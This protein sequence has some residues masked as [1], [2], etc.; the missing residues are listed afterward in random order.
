MQNKH[1][2]IHFIRGDL[3]GRSFVVP[4]DGLLIGKSRSAAIRPGD[5]EIEAEHALLQIREDQLILVSRTETVFVRE[6]QL[7]P[8]AECILEPGVDVRLGKNLSFIL[9]MDEGLPEDEI[10]GNDEETADEA[11]AEDSSD[12]DSGKE[13]NKR[14]GAHTRYASALELQDLRSFVQRKIRRRRILLSISVLLFLVIVFG[15]FLYT[16]FGTE[17]PVTWPGELNDQ[18]NDGEFRIELP[19]GGKFM[20]YFPKCKLTRINEGKDKNNCDIMTLLGKNLDVPFHL[21][22]TVNTLSNGYIVPRKKSFE[23]WKKQA[24]EK[25]NFT[26]ITL[27]EQKFYSPET[28]GY[29]YYSVGYKRTEKNFQWQGWVSYLRYQN[30]E[31]IFL[32]EVPFHHYW[33]TE[34]VLERFNCFV[35]SPDARFSYWE[36]PNSVS[37]K[38]SKTELYK[39]LLEIMW[40]HL[41]TCNWQDVENQFAELLSSSYHQNDVGMARDALLLWQE[42]RKRQHLWYCQRCLAYQQYELLQDRDGMIRVRNECLR[43]FPDKND[44]RH[45]K[46]INNIWDIDQ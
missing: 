26:F 18:F 21:Q 17:N 28:N 41:V 30:K 36:I 2:R 45:D 22:L 38:K 44:C 10:S 23:S 15:G 34:R 11:T 5:R 29:P 19:P 40:G 42:F 3:A 46:I 7:P 39:D 1:Y 9:E 35:V 32:R 4:P 43:K 16:E 33:R 12:M 27:P 25:Q 31:I 14:T 8:D 24:M 6:K 13:E 20:V 37:L